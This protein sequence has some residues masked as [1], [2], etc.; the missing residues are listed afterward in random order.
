MHKRF[1]HGPF[2]RR[3]GA[4]FNELMETSG[5]I[6]GKAARNIFAGS[7]PKV[8][9]FEGPLPPDAP[10]I[11]F[12]SETPPARYSPPGQ[13]YWPQGAPGVLELDPDPRDGQE[14]VGIRVRITKRVDRRTE[15]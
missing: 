8:K 11:E 14:R 3:Q 13:A 12:Y 1:P 2:H 4:V 5:I 10:G 6:G 7:R 9:A 15:T